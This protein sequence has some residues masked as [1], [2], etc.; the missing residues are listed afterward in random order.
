MAPFGASRAGLMSVRR[1]AIPD[2]VEYHYDATELNVSDGSSISTWDDSVGG[3]DLSGGGGASFTNDGI[4]GNP[5]VTFDGV[6]DYFEFGGSVSLPYTVFL[7]TEYFIEDTVCWFRNGRSF[8]VSGPFDFGLF[9]A[10]SDEASDDDTIRN[11]DVMPDSD[12]PSLLVIEALENGDV[13]VRKHDS[14][15]DE[16]TSNIETADIPSHDVGRDSR[17]QRYLDGQIGEIAY[18]ESHFDSVLQS[19][20]NDLLAKW[21]I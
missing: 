18:A 16:V 6:D 10:T 11:D 3:Q 5:S 17:D 14:G 21:G 15:F 19:F 8:E 2:S 7:V 4:N 1:D 20:E 13:T 12:T 9:V